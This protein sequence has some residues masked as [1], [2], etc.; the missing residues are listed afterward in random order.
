MNINIF[1]LCI[2]I[3]LRE[4]ALSG[5]RGMPK[6]TPGKRAKWHLGKSLLFSFLLRKC[7]L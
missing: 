7:K 1:Y 6:G 3:A 5:D 4:R 2:S